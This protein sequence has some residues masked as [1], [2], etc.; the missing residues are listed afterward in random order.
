M[1]R[2]LKFLFFGFIAFIAFL[3]TYFFLAEEPVMGKIE[4]TNGFGDKSLTTITEENILMQD[5]TYMG[6][7]E[8]K[9]ENGDVVF[10]GEDFNGVYRVILVNNIFRGDFSIPVL[11]FEVTG[12]NFSMAFIHNNKIVEY[13]DPAD[14]HLLE[15]KDVSGYI[16]LVIAGESANF[17]FTLPGE[18]YDDY[19]V[20]L[21]RR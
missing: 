16:S 21:V 4:D 7:E 11:D 6:L 5:I 8:T 20:I 3:L 2:G 9:K 1:G 14:E 18:L 19:K 10:S 13:V 12:G 15:L 17:E